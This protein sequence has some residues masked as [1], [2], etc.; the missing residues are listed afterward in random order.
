MAKRVNDAPFFT[1]DDHGWRIRFGQ[2][3]AAGSGAEE[4]AFP[5]YGE[6]LRYWVQRARF[7]GHALVK[8]A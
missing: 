7:D 6:A 8:T 4:A 2:P 5:T 1:W 3:P